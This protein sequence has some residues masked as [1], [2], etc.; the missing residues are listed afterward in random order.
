MGGRHVKLDE[1][2]KVICRD[3]TNLYGYSMIQPLPYDKIEMWHGNPD[4][5]KKKYKKF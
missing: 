3:A 4:L 5:Y 1:N 2:K